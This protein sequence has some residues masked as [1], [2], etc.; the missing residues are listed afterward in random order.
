[1]KEKYLF[2]E[3]IPKCFISDDCVQVMIPFTKGI[4]IYD[5]D[6]FMGKDIVCRYYVDGSKSAINKYL[7]DDRRHNFPCSN[8]PL[9][10]SSNG[11][12]KVYYVN[13]LF[14]YDTD[15]CCLVDHIVKRKEGYKITYTSGY[16]V[17]SYLIKDKDDVFLV[18]Q[19]YDYGLSDSY[20]RY[21]SDFKKYTVEEIKG[22]SPVRIR[23]AKLPRYNHL[24]NPNIDKEEIK[25]AKKLV[26][27]LNKK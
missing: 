11:F 2:V 25:E 13:Q 15:Y 9:Y 18:S 12:K 27:S 4:T 20:A 21:K 24:L 22:L 7:N 10:C 16:F 6:S 3:K 5:K 23:E 14:E 26:K 17:H 8:I 1:M 19:Y